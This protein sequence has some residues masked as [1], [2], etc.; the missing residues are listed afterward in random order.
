MN[1]S[2]LVFIFTEFIAA[3]VENECISEDDIVETDQMSC[4]K[5]F[6]L[7]YTTYFF[8]KLVYSARNLTI[9]TSLLTPREIRYILTG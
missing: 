7:I 2:N 5:I 1:Q 9:Y 6:I 3:N 8:S 4:V